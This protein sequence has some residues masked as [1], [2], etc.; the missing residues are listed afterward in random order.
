[1]LGPYALASSTHYVTYVRVRSGGHR[2]QM[3]G[4]ER[5]DPLQRSAL[6]R[7]G[8]DR[9]AGCADLLGTTAGRWS[10]GGSDAASGDRGTDLQGMR[11]LPACGG[12]SAFQHVLGDCQLTGRTAD[13][14]W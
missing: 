9:R 5:R 8:E 13:A 10:T 2:L 1:M 7:G 12:G 4:R 11:A 14:A 6:S 3:G